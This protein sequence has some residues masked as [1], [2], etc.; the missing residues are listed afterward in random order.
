MGLDVRVPVGLLFSAIGL[1]LVL[2]G[3]TSDPRLYERSLGVNVNLWW[4]LV[5]LAFGATMLLLSRRAPELTAPKPP[6]V[7]K[8]REKTVAR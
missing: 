4:G 1:A 3:M 2:Y 5:L 6:S 7:A 8:P